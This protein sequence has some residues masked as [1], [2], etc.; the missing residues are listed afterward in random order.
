[1]DDTLAAVKEVK[2]M[3]SAGQLLTLPHARLAHRLH[4][5]C[6]EYRIRAMAVAAGIPNAENCDLKEVTEQL[7]AV[8][9]GRDPCID[10]DNQ[11]V[12]LGTCK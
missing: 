3:L 1:L 11:G 4:S 10:V 9:F 2:E 5:H 12:R 7:I 6:D 8:M